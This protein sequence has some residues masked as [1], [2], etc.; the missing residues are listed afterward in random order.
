MTGNDPRAT[1]IPAA[2]V[3][4]GVVGL[5]WLVFGG[6][7]RSRKHSDEWGH[8]PAAAA[9]LGPDYANDDVVFDPRLYGWIRE[10]ANGYTPGLASGQT[11]A[12]LGLVGSGA[13][14]HGSVPARVR[15]SWHSANRFVRHRVWIAQVRFHDWVQGN[16]LL[17]GAAA[18]VI[19][20]AV[21]SALIERERQSETERDR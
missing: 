15:H 17:V 20:A 5:A 9:E 13:A 4:I 8:S 18:A 11:D 2:M 12:L 19:G 14:Q 7:T 16:P 3:G 6:K 1:P 10:T 21:G